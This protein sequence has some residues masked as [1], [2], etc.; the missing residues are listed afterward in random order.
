MIGDRPELFRGRHFTDEVIVSCVRWYL[1][2][3]LTYRI[4]RNDNG[5]ASVG[6]SI[7]GPE[8]VA[9]VCTRTECADPAGAKTDKWFMANRRDVC[10][11]GRTLDL[12]I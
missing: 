8:M 4:F 1:R 2:Y 3:S 11:S 5:T 7:Y 9:T 6:G 12:F 10:T